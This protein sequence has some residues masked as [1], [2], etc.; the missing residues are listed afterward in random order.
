MTL[1]AD[2][3]GHPD[4]VVERIS[5]AELVGTFDAQVWAEQFMDIFGGKRIGEDGPDT[6][7]MIGWFANAIMAGWDE[8]ARRYPPPPNDRSGAL[9]G[10]EMDLIGW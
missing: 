3:G 1:N 5:E 7:T 4:R 6:G 2:S 10:E 9:A 8:H